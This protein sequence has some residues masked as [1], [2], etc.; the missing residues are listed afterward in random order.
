M[1]EMISVAA[2]I[3]G[4]E[5]H[6]D[7]VLCDVSRG[8]ELAQGSDT[9]S[10]LGG[11]QQTFRR[12]GE[13]DSGHNLVV[14]HGDGRAAALVKSAQDQEVPGTP[15]HT[16]ARGESARSLPGRG[17]LVSLLEGTDQGS[18]ALGLDGEDAG[19]ARANEAHLLHLV[20]RL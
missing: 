13:V 10:S 17:V 6:D 18:A 16:K 15:R 19:S 3:S 5:G 11:E 9:G 1:G 4:V 7:V 14:G 2:A 8:L 20:E 12:G